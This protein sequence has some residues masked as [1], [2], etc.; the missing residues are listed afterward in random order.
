M[1]ID[2]GQKRLLH[3]ARQRDWKQTHKEQYKVIKRKSRQKHK[4]TISKRRRDVRLAIKQQIFQIL[5]GKCARCGF[6]DVRALQIDHV[7]ATK[8]PRSGRGHRS[9]GR[10]GYTG[11]LEELLSGSPHNYQLLCSNCNWIKRYENHEAP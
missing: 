5:G 11:V 2:S 4:S 7:D 3:N 10:T 1:S 8:R 6:D 9:L